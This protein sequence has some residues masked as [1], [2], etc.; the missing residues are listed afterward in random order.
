MQVK[1]GLTFQEV[2]AACGV[3][4][5]A[6]DLEKSIAGTTLHLANTKEQIEN[7]ETAIR[8]EWRAIYEKMPIMCSVC[9]EISPRVEF[10]ANCQKGNPCQVQ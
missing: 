7:A 2:N 1:D 5:V 8:E 9:K 4:I 10:I 6:P 3:K